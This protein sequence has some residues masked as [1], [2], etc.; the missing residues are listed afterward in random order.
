MM[1]TLVVTFTQA[2]KLTLY[3]MTM[4]KSTDIPYNGGGSYYF[5]VQITLYRLES[6]RHCTGL[7]SLV[8][9]T[10]Y[11]LYFKEVISIHNTVSCVR[12]FFMQRS[13]LPLQPFRSFPY[14]YVGKLSTWF[15]TFILYY[16]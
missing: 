12:S 3:L 6:V 11:L 9:C 7:T 8:M 16:R 13:T 15:E 5:Q 10:A 4:S 2:F 1:K 14:G